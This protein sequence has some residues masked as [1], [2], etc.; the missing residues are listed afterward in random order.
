MLLVLACAQ[1]CS[2][3][4]LGARGRERLGRKYMS[5][6]PSSGNPGVPSRTYHPVPGAVGSPHPSSWR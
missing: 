1:G 5:I 4:Q 2:L 6:R 3:G